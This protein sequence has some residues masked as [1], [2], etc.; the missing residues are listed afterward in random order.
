LQLAEQTQITAEYQQKVKDLE[1]KEK[2]LSHSIATLSE[3]ALLQ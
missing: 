2:E 3:K 1:T